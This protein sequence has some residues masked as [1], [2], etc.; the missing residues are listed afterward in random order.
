MKVFNYLD[1]IQA[2]QEKNFPYYIITGKETYQKN[3]FS[4]YIIHKHQSEGFEIIRTQ[5]VDYKYE[6]LQLHFNKPSLLSKKN[7]VQLRIFKSPD[8]FA[9][10]LLIHHLSS[11]ISNDHL[12]IIFDS[13]TA[14]QQKAKWFQLI[15]QHALHADMRILNI[16]ESIELIKNE[17]KLCKPKIVLTK[18]ALIMLAQKTEGN[19][20]AA[21]QLINTLKNQQQ[22]YFDD[23]SVKKYLF[24][25]MHYNVFDLTKS[26]IESKLIRSLS[27]FHYIFNGRVENPIILWAILKELRIW[28]AL[29]KSKENFSQYQKIFKLN[30]I[31]KKQQNAYIIQ[32]KKFTDH[33]YANFFKQCFKIDLIIKG[34]EQGNLEK[35]FIY[36]INQFH[37]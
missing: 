27:I 6:F 25:S 3:K 26:L 29:S 30:N 13:L 19:L 21:N 35:N 32:A 36:L 8:L 31:R 1:A 16:N 17:F 23:E 15:T 10:K 33:E 37:R 12:I 34:I 18:D 11:S 5:I 20:L 24:D 28:Y 2:T 7:L 4:E 14:L 22:T 9:Q